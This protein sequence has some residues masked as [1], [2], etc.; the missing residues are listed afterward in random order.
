VRL[1]VQELLGGATVAEHA[2]Q[3]AERVAEE[4]PVR[5]G[6]RRRVV[7]ARNELLRL[8]NAIHEVRR[9]DSERAHAGVQPLERAGVVGW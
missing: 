4:R 2:S 3:A 9:R 6:E 1:T 7:A 8:L 5:V